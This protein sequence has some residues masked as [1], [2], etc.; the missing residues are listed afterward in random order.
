MWEDGLWRLTTSLVAPVA[1]FSYLEPKRHIPDITTLDGPE[2]ETLGLVLARVTSALKQ[3]T[4][5]E[6][7]YVNVFGERVAHL[8]FNLAPHTKGD[9]LTGGPGMLAPGADIPEPSVLTEA[10]ASIGRALAGNSG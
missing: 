9:A 5:A 10:A 7:V 3:A 1:G 2:A 4:N 8:H 6:L